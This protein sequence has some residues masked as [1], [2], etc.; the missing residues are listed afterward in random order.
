MNVVVVGYAWTGGAGH[1]AQDTEMYSDCDNY[2]DT[3]TLKLITNETD[4]SH[5][6]DHM[7]L[8]IP[9]LFQRSTFLFHLFLLDKRFIGIQ[10]RLLSIS[11]TIW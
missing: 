2:T 8:Q 9:P 7:L 10:K 3:N 1:Q 6:S 11:S 4:I 5:C